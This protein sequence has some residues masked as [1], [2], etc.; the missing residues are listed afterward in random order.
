MDAWFPG[1]MLGGK[2][3][4]FGF[5]LVNAREYISGVWAGCWS[6]LGE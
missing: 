2:K 5:D 1:I 6:G 3:V 4:E